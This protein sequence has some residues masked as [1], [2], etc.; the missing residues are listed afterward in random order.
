[1]GFCEFFQRGRVRCFFT[2]IGQGLERG[3]G[4]DLEFIDF[5]LQRGLFFNTDSFA[6]L[7]QFGLRDFLGVLRGLEGFLGLFDG[8]ELGGICR[9]VRGQACFFKSRFGIR[10][11]F[12]F[13]LE[14]FF[15]VLENLRGRKHDR[16]VCMV[17]FRQ[18]VAR[19][20]QQGMCALARG[21]EE[22]TEGQDFNQRADK[23]PCADFTHPLAFGELGEADRQREAARKTAAQ[24]KPCVAFLVVFR[25]SAFEDIRGALGKAAQGVADNRR[26]LLE[27]AG[28]VVV[29]V[30]AREGDNVVMRFARDLASV[31]DRVAGQ[32]EALEDL[33]TRFARAAQ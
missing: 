29:L 17:V 5:S 19:A 6:G 13:I 28:D 14:G 8:F 9:S 2:G 31:L 25:G 1:M 32:V 3:I 4:F 27:F 10:A 12:R 26:D 21:E 23:G 18:V 33:I 24:A 20:L 11:Q 7:A 16:C 15:R 22:V 30:D